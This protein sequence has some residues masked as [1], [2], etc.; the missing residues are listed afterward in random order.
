[1]LDNPI[2]SALE[3]RQARFALGSGRVKRYPADIAPFIATA[4]TQPESDLGG[5]AEAEL[6]EMTTPGEQ[7]YMIGTAALTALRLGSRTPLLG[8]P[9]DLRTQPQHRK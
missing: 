9:D 2:W 1:M 4:E 7:L 6:L 5:E 3:T 8:I